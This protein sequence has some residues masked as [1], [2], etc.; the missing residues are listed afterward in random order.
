MADTEPTTETAEEAAEAARRA[1]QFHRAIGRHFGGLNPQTG[2]TLEIF[3]PLEIQ[4]PKPSEKRA[5]D[6][7][8]KM[9]QRLLTEA[10]VS[11]ME[12]EPMVD[13]AAGLYWALYCVRVN[14]AEL[15]PYAPP[16]WKR[17]EPLEWKIVPGPDYTG[18]SEGYREDKEAWLMPFA[19]RLTPLLRRMKLY[20]R[21]EAPEDKR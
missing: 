2:P 6:L 3:D 16:R 15:E 21:R 11:D 10:A 8:R 9:W 12:Q 5:A 19:E 14:G 18:G 7:D 20:A 1:E 17:G 13:P 4:D